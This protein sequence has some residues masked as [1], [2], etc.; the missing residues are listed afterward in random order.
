MVWCVGILVTDRD[1]AVLD[2]VLQ[3]LDVA[4]K[5]VPSTLVVSLRQ[6]DIEAHAVLSAFQPQHLLGMELL[7]ASYEALWTPA[8]HTE[9]V[10]EAICAQRNAILDYAS[11]RGY[12]ALLF[13]DSD[14]ELE[15]DA[16]EAMEAVPGPAVA[17]A[18][19]PRWSAH[20]VVGVSSDCPAGLQLLL[21]PQ[22]A[23]NV[24]PSV[25]GMGCLLLRGSALEV[26]AHVATSI[27]GVR[28]EDVGFCHAL[29]AK[30]IV[31]HLVPGHMAHH[32][33]GGTGP[34][35]VP[36]MCSRSPLLTQFTPAHLAALLSDQTMTWTVANGPSPDPCTV[37]VAV[38]YTSCAASTASSVISTGT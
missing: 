9:A 3:R 18:Y 30:G 25:V 36:D 33:A 21:N 20:C 7:E 31:I 22:Y 26:R 5:W 1:A 35:V 12:S 19:Q 4:A 23:S 17:M 27:G 38:P 32:L 29:K 13:L 8:Y 2:Q 10:L 15:A 37:H 14:M 6:Q 16:L 28:G 24:T 11:A 34:H